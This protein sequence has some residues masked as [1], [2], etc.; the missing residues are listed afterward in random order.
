ML[1]TGLSSSLFW[2]IASFLSHAVEWR[3]ICLIYAAMM[4]F[5]SLPLLIFGLP[6]REQT[7]PETEKVDLGAP[8]VKAAGTFWLVLAAITPN[9]FITYGFSTILIELL[10]AEGLQPTEAVAFGSTL[11]IIQVSARGI[12]FLGGGRWDGIATGLIAGVALPISMVILIVGAGSYWSIAAFIL[13]YGLGSGAL[14]VARA[15][16]PLV[17]FNKTAYAKATSQI[18][19]PLNAMSAISAP[20]LAALLTHFGCNAV[21]GVAILCSCSALV[22]LFILRGRR[23]RP[24]IA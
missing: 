23:P 1:V 18:A 12:D 5:L 10:K 13:L 20:A 2:P 6:R 9:A 11:G 7:Q 15:T 8:A 21:L 4:A 24:R 17:F 14:A 16:I 22:I 19:L 3:I